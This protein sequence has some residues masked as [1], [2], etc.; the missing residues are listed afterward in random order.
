MLKLY[1]SN[2]CSSCR[3]VKAF[4]NKLNIPYKEINI[5]SGQLTKEDLKEIL[6]KSDYGTDDLVSTRSKIMKEHN[7]D[8]ESMKLNDLLDFILANPT[9]MKRPII[10][11]DRKIE[12]GYDPDEITAFLPMAMKQALDACK[13]CPMNGTCDHAPAF[14]PSKRDEYCDSSNC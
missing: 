2:S 13:D 3:K 1:V 7:I 5:M 11:D 10:V 8:I 6:A 14:M 4:F 9:V 12:V